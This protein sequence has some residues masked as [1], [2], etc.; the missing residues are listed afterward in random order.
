MTAR[1]RT[2]A[3]TVVRIILYL[4][5]ATSLAVAAWGVDW[6]LGLVVVAAT[7]LIG[8]ALISTRTGGAR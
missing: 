1:S 7:A 6:R 2:V 4:V 3:A 8:E 5:A